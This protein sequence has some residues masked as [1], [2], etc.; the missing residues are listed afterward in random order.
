[1]KEYYHYLLGIL[2]IVTCIFLGLY[3]RGRSLNGKKQYS[4]GLKAIIVSYLLGLCLLFV[5]IVS[6]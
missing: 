4:I 1:M 3:V 6:V 5:A 2:W